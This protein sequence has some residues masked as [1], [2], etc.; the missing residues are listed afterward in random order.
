MPS[1]ILALAEA[2]NA[3]PQSKVPGDPEVCGIDALLL[4]WDFAMLDAAL[5]A[6]SAFARQFSQSQ[7][8]VLVWSHS[9]IPIWAEVNTVLGDSSSSESVKLSNLE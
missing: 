2:P 5:S 6:A 7:L 9:G 1:A 3:L 8:S 4:L